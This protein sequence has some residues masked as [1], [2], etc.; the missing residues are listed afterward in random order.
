MLGSVKS[1]LGL[2]GAATTAARVKLISTGEGVG[3]AVSLIL[4]GDIARAHSIIPLVSI[5]VFRSA[6][7]Y[8]GH[9]LDTAGAESKHA[10]ALFISNFVSVLMAMTV[11]NIII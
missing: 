4:N 6:V 11:I 3:V 9:M 5:T 10:P 7:Q 2:P 1:I 8:R